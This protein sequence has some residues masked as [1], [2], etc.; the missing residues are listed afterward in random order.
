MVLGGVV[1]GVPLLG[2][3]PVELPLEPFDPSLFL[4]FFVSPGT[5][6]SP[7]VTGGITGWTVCVV[8]APLS[9]PPPLD[10][11]AITT[12]RKKATPASAA[13]LRRR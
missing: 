12:I 5:T 13:S 8:P 2:V 4:F 3:P 6:G 10:A 1:D 11:I 9:L 7:A